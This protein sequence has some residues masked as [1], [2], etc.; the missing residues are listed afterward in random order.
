MMTAFEHA[1]ACRPSLARPN[2]VSLPK[3]V[4][5]LGVEAQIVR[6]RLLC[7]GQRVLGKMCQSLRASLVVGHAA[8]GSMQV[9]IDL[10]RLRRVL[11][12]GETALPLNLPRRISL[13]PAVPVWA[14]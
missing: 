4:S 10:P 6:Y 7:P 3:C 9:T 5:G 11:P 14:E 8:D 1:S 2:W 13:L 12:Q